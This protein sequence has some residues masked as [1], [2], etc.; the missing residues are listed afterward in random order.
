MAKMSVKDRMLA[1]LQGR[2]HDRVPFAQYVLSKGFCQSF[3]LR[4][5]VVEAYGPDKVGFIRLCGIFGF[6]TPN[7]TW[8][9]ESIV[10]NGHE[11]VRHTVITPKGTL[12]EIRL[13]EQSMQSTAAATHYVKEIEDY[14]A[15]LAYLHDVRVFE[16]LTDFNEAVEELGEYGLAY[17]YLP[18]TPYQQMWIQWTDMRDLAIHLAEAPELMEEV[19]SAIQR[20][21]TKTLEIVCNIIQHAPVPYLVFGDNLTAPM[22]GDY[23]FRKYNVPAYNQMIE[24]IKETGRKVPV[25]VHSDGYLKGLWEA[26]D[27]VRL[28]GLESLS[29]PPDNDTSIADAISR[30]P[31]M[32]FLANFPS[33]AHL[34][35]DSEDIY[36]VAM[37]MLQDGARKGKLQIQISEDIG[38]GV[39]RKSYPQI[40]KAIEDFGAAC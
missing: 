15:L 25:L 22:I 37:Q 17:C 21:N 13:L 10:H 26:F 39:W 16:D 12:N 11:A 4:R 40:I 8:G 28:D 31:Q 30:W 7:C 38:P 20:V 24:M 33:P 6:D 27:E 19:F 14:Q 2:E 32:R 18:R 23:Y 3:P 9:Q 1:V 5:E 35:E 34:Y 36:A 29:P